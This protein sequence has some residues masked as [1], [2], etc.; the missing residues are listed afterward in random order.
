VNRISPSMKVFW[1]GLILV[2]ILFWIP[3]PYVVFQ[4]GTAE[5]VKPMVSMESGYTEEKGSLMLTTV[6]MTY[7]NAASYVM[8]HLNPHA[9]IYKKSDILQGVTDEEYSERQEYNMLTSQSDAVQAAYQR[10]DIPYDIVTEEIRVI[11]TIEGMPAYDILKTGDRLLQIDDIQVSTREELVDYITQK[12][13][14]DQ[15][16]VSFLREEEERTANM[17]LAAA[18]GEDSKPAMGVFIAN[19]QTIQ[20]QDSAKQVYIKAGEIG[21]PSAGLIFSLEIFNRLVPED[22]TKGYQIAGTGEITPDGSVGVIGGIQ[23]K[24]VAADKAGAELFFAP[25]G[26][27][28]I[29]MEQAENIDTD[30]KIIPVKTMG[31][32]LDYLDAL[33]PK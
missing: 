6:R 5:V 7:S 21:G 29:A 26:N 17:L 11:G 10:A 32:A 4:P 2:M 33:P 1:L 30:M 22:I 27:A 8:V 15:I 24:V 19:I 20:A 14:G 13:V 3:T 18:D 9:D 12:H 25:E 31:E 28:A 16:R 23:Y